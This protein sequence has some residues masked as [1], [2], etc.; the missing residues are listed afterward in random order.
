MDFARCIFLADFIIVFLFRLILL[1]DFHFVL[2]D[3]RHLK[4]L[5]EMV[6]SAIQIKCY[7]SG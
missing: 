5:S 4:V 7:G 1:A 3:M 2:S 6:K